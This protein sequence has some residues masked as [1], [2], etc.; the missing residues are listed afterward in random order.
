M[1]VVANHVIAVASATLYG[2]LTGNGSHGQYSGLFAVVGVSLKQRP[3][4]YCF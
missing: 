4:L 3:K 2:D 1:L